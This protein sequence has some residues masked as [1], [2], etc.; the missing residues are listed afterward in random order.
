MK[1]W[2]VFHDRLLLGRC[3]R[4]FVKSVLEYCSAVCCCSAADTHLTLLDR[5]VSRVSFLTGDVFESDIAHLRSGAVLCML[6]KIMCNST[7]PHY[8]ALSGS[9]VPV[10]VTSSASFAH[11]LHYAP[12]RCRTSQFR[13]TFIPL[14]VSL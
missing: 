5:V 9:Y 6:Y 4:D 1:S 7:H 12:S 10:R 14:S 2:R 11:Q 3:F 13:M 8:G